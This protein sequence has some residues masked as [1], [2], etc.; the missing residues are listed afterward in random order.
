MNKL[1]IILTSMVLGAMLAPPLSQAMSEAGDRKMQADKLMIEQHKLYL[2]GYLDN[3][4]NEQDIDDDIV[5]QTS[6]Q[7][8]AAQHAN[9]FLRKI[10]GRD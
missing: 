5:Y 7:R 6:A 9:E 8:K 4:D 10:N 1:A 2:G 3:A